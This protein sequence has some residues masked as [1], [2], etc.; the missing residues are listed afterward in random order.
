MVD[1]FTVGLPQVTLNRAEQEQ[2][3]GQSAEL[4]EGERSL[5]LQRKWCHCHVGLRV[6][7][8]VKAPGRSTPDDDAE[9]HVRS[10]DLAEV[11]AGA[12]FCLLSRRHR[13]LCPT[14]DT[15]QQ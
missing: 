11:C 1:C 9:M 12:A 8:R 7:A 13:S 14:S 4:L 5:S 10:A 15:A 2:H 6:S 3:T